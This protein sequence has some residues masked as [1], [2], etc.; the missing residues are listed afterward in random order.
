MT[1]CKSYACLLIRGDF[2][3][4]DVIAAIGKQPSEAMRTGEKDAVRKVPRCSILEYRGSET[5]CDSYDLGPH[6]DR[7]V[8]S[9]EGYEER[10]RNARSH[11]DLD[12]TLE[13]VLYVP[14]DG[15]VSAPSLDFSKK[16][17]EFLSAIGGEIDVDIYRK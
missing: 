12:L 17:I 8:E 6:I 5:V 4:P 1:D 15:Q 11:W 2:D 9:L 7:V 13:V 3:P 16:V 14:S 10:I